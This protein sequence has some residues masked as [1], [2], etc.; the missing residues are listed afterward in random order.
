MGKTFQP[1]DLFQTPY[2]GGKW[3]Q[4]RAVGGVGRQTALE[5]GT[6]N[7]EPGRMQRKIMI[8]SGW[9]LP[10]ETG[11][12]SRVMGVIGYGKMVSSKANREVKNSD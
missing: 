9:I 5:G 7:N 6:E 4:A 8:T 12:Q 3:G 11:F 2:S 1:S 10:R